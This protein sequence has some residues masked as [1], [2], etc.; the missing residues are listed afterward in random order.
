MAQMIPAECAATTESQAEVE[1]FKQLKLQLDDSW[2]VFHSFTLLAKNQ[3]EKLIDAEIDFLLF[4]PK[5]GLLSL[6]VK[7][8]KVH[9]ENGEWYQYDKKL[10]R[11]PIEQ[12]K[13]NKYSIRSYL[14]N[15]MHGDTE[16]AFGHAVCFPNSGPIRNLPADMK[17]VVI[18]NEQMTYLKEAIET[19]MES[20]SDERSRELPKAVANAVVKTLMPAFEVGVSMND[21]IIHAERQLFSLTEMQ[22][23]LLNFICQ[24][25]K[26]LIQGCAGSGKTIMAIK[27]ARSLA[28][29]GKRVLLMCFNKVLCNRIKNNLADV[30]NITVIT[31]HDFCVDVLKRAGVVVNTE[32]R[33]DA[34]W[35]EELPERLMKAR[36]S[37][38]IEYD[39][40]I[41]DEGQDFKEFFWVSLLELTPD[42]GYFYIFFD[43]AQNLYDTSI[44]LPDLGTPFILNKNCRNSYG[45]FEHIK[46]FAQMDIEHHDKVPDGIGVT[47]FECADDRL[48]RKQLGKILHELVVE[49]NIDTQDITIIGGHSM[50]HTC[51]GKEQ[52]VG[53]FLITENGQNGN[54]TVPYY[55][56]FKYKGCESDVVIILDYDENDPRWQNHNARYTAMSRAK[57]ALYILKK[58]SV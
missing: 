22:C 31:Y 23:E 58:V 4:H 5:K 48:M 9:Q 2:T 45:I 7:G 52:K 39:A 41:I 1:V 34:F 11:S 3:E 51:L 30:N 14:F 40:L 6:E 17:E 10:P 13:V 56:Y 15:H 28:T 50:K 12:A 57:H 32:G 27:K 21:R 25:K 33:G 46:P 29:A 24:H 54:N 36:A 26:A 8:G 43:P 47:E 20:W 35:N 44:A 42:D 49:N 18:T 19:I 53:N 16:M 37:L 38:E 55:S